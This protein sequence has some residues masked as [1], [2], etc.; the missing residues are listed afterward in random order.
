MLSVKIF[1]LRE[2]LLYSEKIVE[3]LIIQGPLKFCIV[4]LHGVS[5]F[6]PNSRV[7][8]QSLDVLVYCHT[9][10]MVLNKTLFL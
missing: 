10:G 7:R 3:S 9:A 1:R 8:V 2:V 5:D 6:A 4:Y